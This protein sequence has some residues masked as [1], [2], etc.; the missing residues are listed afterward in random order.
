MRMQIVA[1]RTKSEPR[2]KWKLPLPSK[3]K[4]MLEIV[5]KPIAV[6]SLPDTFSLNNNK[7]INVVATISKLLSREAFAEEPVL[8]PNIKKTGAKISNSIM[9]IV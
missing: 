2:E 4:I 9:P 7:A 5:I 3:D 8:I 6:Q 1:R